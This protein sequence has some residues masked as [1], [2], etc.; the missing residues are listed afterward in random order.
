MW[1]VEWTDTGAQTSY[2]TVNYVIVTEPGDFYWSKR[3]T[4]KSYIHCIKRCKYVLYIWNVWRCW[5]KITFFSFSYGLFWSSLSFS[6][7]ISLSH[8]YKHLHITQLDCMPARFP[9]KKSPHTALHHFHIF[10][11]AFKFVLASQKNNK[12][13][14]ALSQSL[15]PTIYSS[16]TFA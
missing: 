11:N 2:C 12:K 14:L 16:L 15:P 3:V 9:C 10:L 13:K 8:P 1:H 7:S 5:I 6:L 4:Q